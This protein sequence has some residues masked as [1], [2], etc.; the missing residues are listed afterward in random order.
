[1][2]LP[3]CRG[4]TNSLIHGNWVAIPP[5]GKHAILHLDV[6]GPGVHQP[7]RQRNQDN[8]DKRCQQ[9]L[10]V[11]FVHIRRFCSLPQAIERATPLQRK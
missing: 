2:D 1:M 11:T 9:I 4:A 7:K 8:S 6:Y 5:A 3:A 10:P